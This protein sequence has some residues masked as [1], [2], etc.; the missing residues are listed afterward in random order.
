MFRQLSTIIVITISYALLCSGYNFLSGLLFFLYLI[1]LV[2]GAYLFN[3][4][5]NDNNKEFIEIYSNV[6]KFKGVN[7]FIIDLL[8]LTIVMGYYSLMISNP[9]FIILIIGY[10]VLDF[11]AITHKGAK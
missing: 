5:L 7:Y 3:S 11:K 9:Y 4:L 2:I 6:I 8:L 1:Y 10:A